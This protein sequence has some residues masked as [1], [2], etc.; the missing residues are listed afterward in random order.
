[1][2]RDYITFRDYCSKIIDNLLITK[3][4]QLKECEYYLKFLFILPAHSNKI[5]KKVKN[6]SYLSKNYT[7]PVLLK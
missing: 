6:Q 1:M 5:I 2:T 3:M 4:Y 7:Q